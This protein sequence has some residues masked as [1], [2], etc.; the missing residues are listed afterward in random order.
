MNALKSAKKRKKW[1]KISGKIRQTI[2]F[3]V[4]CRIFCIVRAYALFCEQIS[5]Q[6]NERS[7]KI[8]HLLCG[9]LG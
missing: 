1:K 4:V 7:K 9:W 2:V 5:Q 6:R 3:S 8:N